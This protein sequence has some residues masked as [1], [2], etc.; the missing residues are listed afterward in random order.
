MGRQTAHRSAVPDATDGPFE[1]RPG[2]LPGNDRN[3]DQ[4]ADQSESGTRVG[5]FCSMGPAATQKTIDLF[6]LW[7]ET[8]AMLSSPSVDLLLTLIRSNV[9]RALSGNAPIMGLGMSWLWADAV[10]AFNTMPNLSEALLSY[11]TCL[12]LSTLQQSTSHYPWI[13]V[14]PL[15]ALRDNVLCR[16]E[17]FE[18]TPYCLDEN[19]LLCPRLARLPIWV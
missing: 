2:V 6:H 12:H 19:M 11:P 7:V 5:T 15:P 9:F 10:F 3:S 14:L 13:D 1:G 16:G 8:H 17:L 18:D 4:K